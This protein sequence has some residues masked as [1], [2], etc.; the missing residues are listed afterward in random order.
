MEAD[1]RYRTEAGE[2]AKTAAA[3]RKLRMES[4]ARDAASSFRSD[5]KPKS[6]AT[7]AAVI[8]FVLL[9]CGLGALQLM[10]CWPGAI[11]TRIHVLPASEPIGCWL[12]ASEKI[13][14]DPT[15]ELR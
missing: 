9:A 7:L 4:E 8:L 6:K 15:R 2:R 14:S 10:T 1:A 11:S 13:T 3:D 12:S 5:T